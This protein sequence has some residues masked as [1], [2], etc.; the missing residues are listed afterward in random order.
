MY[1]QFLYKLCCKTFDLRLR[2][3]LALGEML[4]N[5]FWLFQAEMD[6]RLTLLRLYVSFMMQ[7][8]PRG[9]PF[10]SAL[11]IGVAHELWGGRG[12]RAF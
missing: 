8:G 9:T 3:S 2:I 10:F 11:P 5:I 4:S 6:F 12:L 1:K 7:I